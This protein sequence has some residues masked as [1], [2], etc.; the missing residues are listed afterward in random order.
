MERLG[1]GTFK[2]LVNTAAARDNISRLAKNQKWKIEVS[3]KD[4]EYLLVLT[5]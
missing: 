2:V 3:E 4:G 5:K 1:G